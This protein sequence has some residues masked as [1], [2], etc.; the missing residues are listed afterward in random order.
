MKLKNKNLLKA[1]LNNFDNTEEREGKGYNDD[2]D[3]KKRQEMCAD[4]R[5]F[6]TR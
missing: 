6:F 4:T 2:E 1:D 3:R 5:A